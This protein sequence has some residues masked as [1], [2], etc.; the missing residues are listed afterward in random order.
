[1]SAHENTRSSQSQVAGDQAHLDCKPDPSSETVTIGNVLDDMIQRWDDNGCD[2]FFACEDWYPEV[3]Y[4]YRKGG[5]H[6][7]LLGDYI[8]PE[9]QYRLVHKL[10]LG[11][12]GIV[13]LCQVVGC[14]PPLYVAAKTLTA[15]CSGTNGDEARTLKQLETLSKRHPEIWDYILRPR[16]MFQIHG[17]NGTHDCVIYPVAGA[18]VKTIN[19]DGI[20][21]PQAYL[22][23]FTRQSAQA[24]ASIHR[25]GICHGDFRPGNI[26]LRIKG[27]NGIPLE[28]VY[29]MVGGLGAREAREIEYEDEDEESPVLCPPKYLIY[30]IQDFGPC[31]AEMATNKLCVVD[32]GESFHVSSP[33]EDGTRIPFEYAAP[34]LY[35]EGKCG[36]SSD[37]WA[38]ACTLVEIRTGHRLFPVCQQWQELHDGDYLYA[39][40]KGLGIPPE[41]LWSKH[42]EDWEERCVLMEADPD[43]DALVAEMTELGGHEVLQRYL[44]EI[45][46]RKCDHR[47]DTG[48]EILWREP[49]PEDERKPF[50]DLISKMLAWEPEKRLTI[51]QVLEHPW[52]SYDSPPAQKADDD[53]QGKITYASLTL[54]LSDIITRVLRS[55]FG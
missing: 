54:S 38:L 36:F 52:F 6:P 8:G 3:E 22:R 7:L 9:K 21:D 28:Q 32:W 23:A 1:M 34:E 16:D 42:R 43:P 13:W 33:P 15:D 35:F 20:Q 31:T 53:R 51:Q 48:L 29:E 45:L 50:A 2:D 49:M 37:M 5:H 44:N 25:H 10:G 40:V 11:A 27:L 55:V 24:M 30:P 39:I 41:S 4:S 26:L 47:I 18:P 17:P 19:A 12:Y 14:D 46:S